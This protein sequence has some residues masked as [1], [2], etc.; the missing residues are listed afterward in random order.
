VQH[1]RPDVS[2]LDEFE[3]RGVFDTVAESEE[4]LSGGASALVV[5]GPPLQPD[6]AL[7]PVAQPT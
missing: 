6:P 5:D 1:R 4:H 2:R 7:C 3:G